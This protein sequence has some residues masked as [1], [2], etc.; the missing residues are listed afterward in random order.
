MT[1]IFFDESGFSLFSDSG[2]VC[3]WRLNSQEFYIKG[4][5]TVKHG[6]YSIIVWVAIWI[7]DCSEQA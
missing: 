1:V 5:S 7:I 6:G 2:S 3:F 4:I